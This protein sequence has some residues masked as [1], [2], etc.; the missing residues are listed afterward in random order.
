M[1]NIKCQIAKDD[2]LKIYRHENGLIQISS[3][4]YPLFSEAKVRLIIKML[5]A[6]LTKQT[7]KKVREKPAEF[8]NEYR[9]VSEKLAQSEPVG[10]P[11]GL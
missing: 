1:P 6:N 3:E 11:R 10:V 9:T 8:C 4:G 2:Y 5:E 7:P